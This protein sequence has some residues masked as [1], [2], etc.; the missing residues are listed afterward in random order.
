MFGFNF[1]KNYFN[2]QKKKGNANKMHDSMLDRIM[3]APV[4]LFF[5]THRSEKI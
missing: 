4:N 1:I 3:A 5:D 2:H